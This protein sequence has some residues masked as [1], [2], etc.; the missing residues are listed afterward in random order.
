VGY[1]DRLG[2]LIGQ[3]G[4]VSGPVESSSGHLGGVS[5]PVGASSR[6]VGWGI[7]TGFVI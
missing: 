3:L 5:R 2:H 7:R 1:Q 6:P 4:G